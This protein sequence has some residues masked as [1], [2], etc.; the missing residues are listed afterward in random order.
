[1]LKEEELTRIIIKAFYKV[2]NT[3]GYG[4]L[5]RVY[6]KALELELRKMGLTVQYKL[7]IEVYYE[8]AQVGIYQADLVINNKIIIEIKAAEGLHPAHEAQLVNYLRA[9]EI[10]IG[11]LFNFGKEPQFVRKFFSNERKNLGQSQEERG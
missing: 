1:M 4:F 8:G 9:T 11:F 6:H 3:L 2:Y 10:E 7:R 5:E